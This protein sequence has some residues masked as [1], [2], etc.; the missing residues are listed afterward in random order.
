MS[1][2]PSFRAVRLLDARSPERSLVRAEMIRG[3]PPAALDDL[4][5]VWGEARRRMGFLEHAH[6]DWRNK[7]EGVESG[8]YLLV[9][10]AC[11][12]DFQG[13]MA[14]TRTPRPAR[15]GDGHV[16]YVDY[17]E[18]APWNLKAFTDPPRFLGVGTLLLA[19]A[20]CLSVETG[21]GGRVGL[22]SLPQAEPFYAKCRMTRVG[23][24][25]DYYDLTYFEYTE[26]QATD[27]LAA[28]GEIL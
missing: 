7:A 15:L 14:A 4:E 20:V 3:L 21:H 25:P 16:V 27:W 17:L 28:V 13:V 1:T 19:D 22:H 8:R 2:A 5:A 11:A 9:A 6:W 24:D 23:P 18:A 26:R 10:V 12:G